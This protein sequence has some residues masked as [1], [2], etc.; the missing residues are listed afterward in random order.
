MC[1]T[2]QEVCVCAGLRGGV[3]VCRT[4]QEVCVYA[5]LSRRCVCVQ[6]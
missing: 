3:C 2:E 5:G 4:E 6:D 1:R